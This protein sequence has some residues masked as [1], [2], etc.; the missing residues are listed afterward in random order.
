MKNKTVK[1]LYSLF[2]A[3]LCCAFVFACAPNENPWGLSECKNIEVE[4][5]ALSSGEQ[6]LT[7]KSIAPTG[8]GNKARCKNTI[9]VG[10]ITL[11][12]ALYGKTLT[13][14]VYE[15]ENSVKLMLSGEV[16]NFDGVKAQAQIRVSKN[17]LYNGY[18]STCS[19][20]IYKAQ[21]LASESVFDVTGA[22]VQTKFVL[23]W[24]NFTDK[25]TVGAVSLLD[26]TLGE[27]SEVE[28]VDGGSALVVTVSDFHGTLAELPMIILASDTTT[29]GVVITIKMET[30][31]AF[32]L[33]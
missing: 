14:V 10:E 18:D 26:P 31:S 16:A 9:D 30:G 12:G 2:V 7:V 28:V 29:F 6:T 3:M 25:A 13:A 19:F 11:G 23:P 20:E 15:N 8:E 4:G 33:D 27:V 1:I 21:M 22:S 24:G 5:R 17:A 32:D